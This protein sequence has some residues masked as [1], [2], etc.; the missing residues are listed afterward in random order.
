MEQEGKP[1]AEAGHHAPA[2]PAGK[3]SRAIAAAGG[4]VVVALAFWLWHSRDSGRAPVTDPAEIERQ[5]REQ[6]DDF[7]AQLR[8]GE[9]LVQAKRMDEAAPIL[10]HAEQ[11]APND[12][13]PYAWLGV[14]AI[15]ERRSSEAR[16]L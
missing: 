15:S 3:R 14:V 13:R 1:G 6:P 7:L 11:L 10:T 9:A 12:A 5:A 16:D 4:I 8:W 2:S